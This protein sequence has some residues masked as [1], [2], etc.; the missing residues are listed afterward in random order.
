MEPKGASDL[1]LLDLAEKRFGKKKLA[2]AL[3]VQENQLY[4][5]RSR[6]G[7]S[8]KARLGIERLLKP[9]ARATDIPLEAR[10]FTAT[11]IILGRLTRDG[12]A[13]S[14]KVI[15]ELLQ[16]IGEWSEDDRRRVLEENEDH[17]PQI[18]DSVLIPA[19]FL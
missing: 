13:D 18:R 3:K 4:V 16:R 7:L 1:D 19:G 12:D 2:E 17:Y 11:M 15:F 6:K 9:P 5:Y 14:L 8:A 10:Y